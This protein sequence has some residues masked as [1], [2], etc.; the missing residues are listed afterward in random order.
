MKFKSLFKQIRDVNPSQIDDFCIDIEFDLEKEFIY[1]G[2][3][4][5]YKEYSKEELYVPFNNRNYRITISN[6]DN[7]Y[8]ELKKYYIDVIEKQKKYVNYRSGFFEL[9]LWAKDNKT[10]KVLA[11]FGSSGYNHIKYILK[12]LYKVK[13]GI[14]F[15]LEEGND[16][17]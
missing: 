17:Y 14:L 4:D 3:L 5:Q 11:Y 8:E 13:K 10:G 1:I 2:D 9:S 15:D 7:S 16:W 6:I 12:Q